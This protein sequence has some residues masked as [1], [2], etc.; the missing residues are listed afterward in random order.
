MRTTV[1]LD[2]DVAEKLKAEERRSGRSF[3][4][5]LNATLR[6]GLALK[7][8]VKKAE[9]FRVVARDLGSLRPGMNLD[10]VAE[11]LEQVEG[12]MAR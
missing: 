9:R 2:D 8:R 5:T 11:L 3:K 10:N 6:R 4:E 1:T 12:P 7:K